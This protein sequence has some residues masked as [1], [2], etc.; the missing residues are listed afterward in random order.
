MALAGC[1]FQPLYG[2]DGGA[3]RGEVS[4]E[5][6]DGRLAYFYRQQLRRRFGDP[7]QDAAY[8]LETKLGVRREGYAITATDDVTRFDVIGEATFVLRRK[9]D[10]SEAAR[11]T[12]TS[13]TAYSTTATPYATDV[14]Q[15]DAER[16]VA[17][18]LADRVFARVAAL[19][20]DAGP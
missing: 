9:S 6:E 15:R 7:A 8:V 1:G 20:I 13:T 16:R 12:T 14:A 11:G 18:D 17:V 4:F 3:L 5:T 2:E 10:G 19:R